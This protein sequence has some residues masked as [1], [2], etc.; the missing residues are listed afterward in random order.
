M[1]NRATGASLAVLVM[2]WIAAA[3]ISGQTI[4]PPAVPAPAAGSSAAGFTAHTIDTA[5]PAATRPS[6]LI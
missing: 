1:L 6:S 3:A 4:G 5:S 2:G